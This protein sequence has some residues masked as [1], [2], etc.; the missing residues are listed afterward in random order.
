MRKLNSSHFSVFD[1]C[2]IRGSIGVIELVRR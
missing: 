1:P 2:L